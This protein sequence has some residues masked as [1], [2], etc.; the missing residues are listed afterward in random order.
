MYVYLLEAQIYLCKTTHQP[1]ITLHTP[2]SAS[3]QNN[4]AIGSRNKQLVDI[5]A[6]YGIPV[7]LHCFAGQNVLEEITN[8]TALNEN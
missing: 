2:P 8:K 4:I 6:I 5:L 3:Q 1:H 7:M